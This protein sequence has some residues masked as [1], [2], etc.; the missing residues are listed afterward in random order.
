MIKYS[1]LLLGVEVA[2]LLTISKFVCII[3]HVIAES[4]ER[5]AQLII[6]RSYR[7]TM[8]GVVAFSR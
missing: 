3:S 7:Q 2:F 6:S 5:L 8:T 1:A 4:A